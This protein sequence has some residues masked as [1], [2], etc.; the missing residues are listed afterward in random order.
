MLIQKNSCFSYLPSLIKK[1]K[2]LT[3]KQFRR[4]DFNY[5]EEVCINF[6]FSSKDLSIIVDGNLNPNIFRQLIVKML[7][8]DAKSQIL[9]FDFDLSA[10][11]HK[12]KDWYNSLKVYAGSKFLPE[13]SKTG[14]I[15]SKQQHQNDYA[16][17]WK[18]E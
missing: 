9:I 4:K 5:Y 10:Y 8:Y 16:I 1:N 12:A 11:V 3:I 6:T 15:Q 13:E 7:T 17:L 14:Y 18:R 2:K